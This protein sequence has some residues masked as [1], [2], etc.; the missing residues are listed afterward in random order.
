MNLY[1]YQYMINEQKR[2]L[3]QINREAWKHTSGYLYQKPFLVKFITS[4]FKGKEQF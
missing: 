1:E 3:N 4:V 2:L